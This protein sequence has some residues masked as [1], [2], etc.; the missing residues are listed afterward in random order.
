MDRVPIF[1]QNLLT[2]VCGSVVDDDDFLTVIRQRQRGIHGVPYEL[3]LVMRC[4]DDAESS[5]SHTL[6]VPFEGAHD[7]REIIAPRCCVWVP[8]Q[9]APAGVA[10]QRSEI[11]RVTRHRHPH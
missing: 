10:R 11:F 8:C 1:H 3:A 4:D 9:R 2:T 6:I 5:L 7:I